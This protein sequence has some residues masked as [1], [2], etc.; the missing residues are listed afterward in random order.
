MYPHP[1]RPNCRALALVLAGLLAAPTLVPAQQDAPA[2]DVGQLLQALHA[3]RQQQAT[4]LKTQKQT[5]LQQI[6]AAAGSNERATA[7]WETAVRATQMEGAGKEN[8]QLKA[9]KEGEGESFKEREVQNAVRLH[10][11][12]LAFTLQRSGG[13]PVKEML[14]SLVNYTKELLA[15]EATMEALQDAIKRDKELGANSPKRAQ[16]GRDDAATKKA[17]DGVLKN[18]NSSVVVQWM[19]LNDFL[20]VEHWELNPGNLDGIY[21][22]IILPEMRAQKDQHVFDYWDMKLKKEA[23]NATQ[24]KLAFEVE[25]F[26]TLRRP[27]LLW[28][29]ALEY[30]ALGL[31]NKAATEMFAL[32][33]A[34]PTHPDADDWVA[35]LEE[36]VSPPAPVA[37]AADPSAA[38]AGTAT[39]P[40]NPAPARLPGQ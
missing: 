12:W 25:K 21:R 20:T 5:A 3:I 16:R 1:L 35:K 39:P 28:N 13:T 29:R 19:K 40:A 24:S 2:V 9:W 10:L 26:N 22:N 17:H 32:I 11:E 34:N 36:M 37:P 15:D 23:D 7:L 6:T 8:S 27:T 4:Q 38:S 33:K 30:A 14:P 18:L 31:K